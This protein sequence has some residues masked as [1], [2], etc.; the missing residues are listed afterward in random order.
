VAK[1]SDG[2][3]EGSFK[4]SNATEKAAISFSTL[5]LLF[6]LPTT[7]A[8]SATLTLPAHKADFAQKQRK[9]CILNG[10]GEKIAIAKITKL[11][12]TYFYWI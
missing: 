6:C 1:L 10:M 2:S 7:S 9:L 3:V 11:L 4:L 5:V 8:L 12:P